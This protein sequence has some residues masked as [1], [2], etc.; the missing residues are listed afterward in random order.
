M[1][2][3]RIVGDLQDCMD[4]N[5]AAICGVRTLSLV[6]TR[7]SEAHGSAEA[8]KDA[9]LL[10]LSTYQAGDYACMIIDAWR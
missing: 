9:D 3:E 4:A 10:Y 8:E 1:T 5:S 6:P 7:S 2:S